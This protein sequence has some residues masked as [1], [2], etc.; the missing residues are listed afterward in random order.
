MPLNTFLIAAFVILAGIGPI[1][2]QTSDASIRRAV[3]DFLRIQIKGLPGKA[4]YTIDTIQSGSLPP[5][6]AFDVSPTAGAQAM[7]RSSVT[8]RCLAGANWS[9]LVP[10]KIHVL[11]NYLVSARSITPGQT[12]GPNDVVSQTGDLG[13]LPAGI[14][15]APEQ[16]I[17]QVA[18]AG[19]PAGRPLRADM[20]KAQ[21][22]IQAG[23]SVKV[24]SNGPGFQVANEGKAM[25]AAVI[26]QV[27]Q[28]RLSSGQVVSGVAS[29]S[30][31]VEI[32]F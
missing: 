16:A 6:S 24:V 11:G 23:Q 12:I 20:L 18:R 7:G 3:D 17:G 13:E 14:L 28:I 26:G 10:V 22:V 19:L 2:A 31:N 9:L 27:V 1:H 15:G 21:T 5:C 4:S 8:V 29:A 30:G 25:G 32:N